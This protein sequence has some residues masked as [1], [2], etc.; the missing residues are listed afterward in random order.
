MTKTVMM[1]MICLIAW[2]QPAW[3][4]VEGEWEITPESE[5]AVER[6]LQWLAQNQGPV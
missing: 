3:G 5:K 4:V 1:I 2:G 6:G